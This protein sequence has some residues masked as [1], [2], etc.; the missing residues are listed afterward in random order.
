M[1]NCENRFEAAACENITGGIA[2]T[3]ENLELAV[4]DGDFDKIDYLLKAGVNCNKDVMEIALEK[5]HQQHKKYM[6]LASAFD[7]KEPTERDIISRHWKTK[8]FEDLHSKNTK[9]VGLMESHLHGSRIS[10]A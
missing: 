6:S 1:G 7:D 3:E 5:H 10:G 2:L 8:T 9:V 4:R